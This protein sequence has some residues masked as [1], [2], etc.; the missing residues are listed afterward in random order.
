MKGDCMNP[1]SM[2]V[3]EAILLFAKLTVIIFW[4]VFMLGFAIRM[5]IRSIVDGLNKATNRSEKET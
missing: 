1:L 5:V 4:A 3:L 2:P